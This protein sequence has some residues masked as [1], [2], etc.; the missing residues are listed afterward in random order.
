MKSHAFK[1]D[2]RRFLRRGVSFVLCL[3]AAC[4]ILTGCAGAQSVPEQEPI[5][6]TVWTYYNGDQLAA[7]Q[8]LIRHFNDTAGREKKITVES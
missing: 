8:E 6:L 3:A 1:K 5:S 2:L 4:G 7:F